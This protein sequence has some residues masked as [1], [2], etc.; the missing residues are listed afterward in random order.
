R[1]SVSSYQRMVDCPYKFFAADVLSLKAEEEITRELQRS[2]Y[3]EK[4]HETLRAFFEQ[5]PQLPPPFGEQ[6]TPDNRQQAIDHLNAIAQ[7]VFAR[8][9]ENNVQH[10]G[11]LQQWSATADTFIDWLIIRQQAW[12]FDQAEIS[13]RHEIDDTTQ[14][15]G[16]LDL[17][18]KNNTGLAIIDYKSGHSPSQQTVNDGENVQLTSYALL[19]DNVK[20]VA[21]LKLDKKKTVFSAQVSDEELE[22]LT[23]MNLLRLRTLTQEIQNG[24]GMTAWG[25]ALTCRFCDMA[26]VCRKQIWE[27]VS[28]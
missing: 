24:Q 26:G 21:F 22:N 28:E 25:D 5:R 7:Q 17:I 13:A 8:N 6:V 27:S 14:L 18:E 9:M 19:M 2:E 16:R 10:K 15:H 20:Q 11:W 4:L 12:R 3:G 23:A 1:W